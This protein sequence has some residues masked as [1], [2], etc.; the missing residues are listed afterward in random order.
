M[1][2]RHTYTRTVNKANYSTHIDFFA[3]FSALRNVLSV[4][5]IEELLG[6]RRL[7]KHSS[8]RYSENLDDL[9]HLFKLRP[10]NRR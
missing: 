3:V 7:V 6:L 9:H 4:D 8:R 1:N 2:S 5:Q 10:T